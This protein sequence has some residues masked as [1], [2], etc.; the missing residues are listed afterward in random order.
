LTATVNPHRIGWIDE[1]PRPVCDVPWLGTSI[2][3]STGDVAFCCY[4][5]D[6]IIG[7]VNNEP[8]ERIWNGPVMQEIRR[9]LLEQRLPPRCQCSMCP[10]YRGDK[11]TYLTGRMEGYFRYDVTGTHDPHGY[12]R[13]WLH[14]SELRVIKKSP[15]AGEAV[16]LEI[17]LRYRGEPITADLFVAVRTPDGGYRFL[18]DGA[19]YALPFV[20]AVELSQASAP[21]NFSAPLQADWLQTEGDYEVCAALFVKDSSPNLLSNCYWSATEPFANRRIDAEAIA[22]RT[23]PVA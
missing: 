3:L 23:E 15:H 7:N 17:E 16:G 5:E 21:L 12:V 1:A 9:A 8:L 14:G 4:S 13:D 18:P 6:P 10:I 2:V 11:L 19:E 22:A 20:P